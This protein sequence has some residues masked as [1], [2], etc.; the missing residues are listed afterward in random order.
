MRIRFEPGARDDLKAAARW[1]ERQRPG[2]GDHFTDAV[3]TAV[4]SIERWPNA[5]I[6]VDEASGGERVRMEQVWGYPFHVV[7]AVGRTTIR[8]G[9]VAHER[10]EP[11]YWR[12][13][14]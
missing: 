3:R 1:Y 9:A 13:R 14:L 6:S 4:E 11:G 8:I 10:Q 12:E 5:G 7:Y 2:L